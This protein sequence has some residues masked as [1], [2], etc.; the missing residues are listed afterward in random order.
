MIERRRSVR[1][2]CEIPTLLR[3]LDSH[4]TQA[5]STAVVMNI[6]RGGLCL[7]MDQFVPIQCHLYVTLHLPS[8]PPIEVRVAPAWIVELPHL[9]KYEMGARFL[10][11][12]S[13][14]EETIQAF[15]Y[16]T[17]LEK[18]PPSRIGKLKF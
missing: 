10:D 17:L 5:V 8:Q 6:S 11:I 16:K 18:I 7:R 13:E 4:D 12:R 1:V 15:Q 3:N 2:P 14:D 9:G